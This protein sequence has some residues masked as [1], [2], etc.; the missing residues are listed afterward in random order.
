MLK[1]LGLSYQLLPREDSALHPCIQRVS[2][3]LVASLRK[4]NT[5]LLTDTQM[6]K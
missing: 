3:T 1:W 2:L 6:A 5:S 4:E